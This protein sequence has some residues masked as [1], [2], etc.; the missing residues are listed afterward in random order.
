MKKRITIFEMGKK[1]K[2]DVERK[3]KK[4]WGYDL[5]WV[6]FLQILSFLGFFF[7]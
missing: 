7:N 2:K 6:F 5:N 1:K 4:R 3:T